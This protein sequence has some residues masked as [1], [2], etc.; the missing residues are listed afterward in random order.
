MS[1]SVLSMFCLLNAGGVMLPRC[2]LHSAAPGKN[3]NMALVSSMAKL[4]DIS[5]AF[6]N[7]AT[8]VGPLAYG[9]V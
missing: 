8:P 5:F 7:P 9:W 2:W 1:K 6:C 3:A 4:V